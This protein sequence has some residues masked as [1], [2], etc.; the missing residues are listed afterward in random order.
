M[1]ASKNNAE[2]VMILKAIITRSADNV[3]NNSKADEGRLHLYRVVNQRITMQQEKELKTN[4]IKMNIKEKWNNAE[5]DAERYE[6]MTKAG[7]TANSHAIPHELDAIRQD[8]YV[9]MKFEQ[10]PVS[11]QQLLLAS[12]QPEKMTTEPKTKFT[13]DEVQDAVIQAYRLKLGLGWSGVIR[14]EYDPEEKTIQ[15]CGKY[16]MQK[17]QVEYDP[18]EK[19]IF[20]SQFPSTSSWSQGCETLCIVDDYMGWSDI[21]EGIHT[22]DD[23]LSVE[24]FDWKIEGARQATK[25]EIEEYGLDE[26]AQIV[27]SE[28]LFSELDMSELLYDAIQ[29]ADETLVEIQKKEEEEKEE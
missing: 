12:K 15:V 13:T 25:E 4:L 24:G 23:N 11:L 6:M 2:K 5:H 7:L 17:F 1:S 9:G 29:E 14:V 16:I 22:C 10:L 20:L 19:T 21:V 26:D 18:E 28:T 27:D 8:E 3:P